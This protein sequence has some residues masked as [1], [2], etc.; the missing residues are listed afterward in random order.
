MKKRLV[1]LC[2]AVVTALSMTGCGGSDASGSDTSAEEGKVLRYGLT[3]GPENM[4]PTNLSE[5]YAYA[6][7]RQCYNGLTDRAADGSVTDDGLAESWTVNEDGTEYD[8][9]LKK[10]VKF[11][12]GKELTSEDV[13]FTFERVLSPEGTGDGSFYLEGIVGAADVLEGNASEIE[14]FK[15]ISDTEF[16]VT[17][18][19]PEYMFPEY[20]SSESL[21][22]VD[23]SVVA[24][25]EDNWWETQSAGTGPFV[26]KS[27]TPDEKIEFTANADYYKGAPEIAGIEFVVVDDDETAYRLYQ[28]DELDVI[29][30]PYAELENIQADDEMKDQLVEYPSASMTYLG[31]NQS[32]YEPFADARVREA[33]SL[34]ISSDTLT[35][36]I[37]G[38][39]AY[40]LYGVIPVDFC[41]YNDEIEAPEYNIEK[42]KELLAEAGYDESNPLPEVSLAYLPMDEDNAVY[43][44]DQLKNELGWNVTLDGPDRS[45]MIDK[46]WEYEYAFFI[47]GGTADYGDAGCL[48]SMFTTDAG[49]NFGEYSN[50]DYDSLIDQA[51]KTADL[52]ERNKLYQDAEKLLMEDHGMIPM[53]VDKT[54]MLVK[55]NVSGLRYSSLGMDCLE[56]VAI[57]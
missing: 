22:I 38:G 42:A 25:A 41:G 20:L 28:N 45:T 12:S 50:S 9:V 56:D 21:Y 53:Y 49:R 31:M 26:L 2:L 57:Q 30:A 23:S 8:F 13:K 35:E 51:S 47:F 4:D 18:E 24:D 27:F 29:D 14:G 11:H 16:K 15:V 52:D 44:A 37:M 3:C 55:P 6:M 7:V 10:G 33:I 36:K 46:L 5:L 34:A 40:P 48:L 17:F 32:L 19:E 54:Y 39:M 1:A 43:I